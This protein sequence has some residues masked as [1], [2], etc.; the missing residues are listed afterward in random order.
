MS[1]I[2]K[3]PPRLP[4][5]FLVEESSET[6]GPSRARINNLQHQVSELVRKNQTLERKLTA[7][8]S[9]SENDLKEKAAK[10][11][12]MQV[13]LHNTQRE[14]ERSKKDLERCVLE[15]SEMK[16]ELQ[17]HSMVQQQKAL[18]AVAQEQM[19]VVELETRLLDAEK[20]R[21]L[22][23]HKITLF[24]AKE[25]ELVREIEERDIRIEDLEAMLERSN[26]SL[27][28]ERNAI[29]KAS[30]SQLTSSKDLTKAQM[31][32]EFARAEINTL[33][34]KVTSLETKVR[35]LKDREKEARSE[36]ESWLREEGSASKHQKEKKESQ[37]QL[38]AMKSELEKKKEE[39][40]EL[41]EELEEAVRSGK[42]KEKILKK[43][44][45]D[46]NEEKERLL[47]IEE[48]LHGLRAG[49]S[50]TTPGN[51][52]IRK[53]SPVKE[54]SGDEVTTK[55]KAKK[56]E[57]AVSPS[58]L[59]SK[60]RAKTK[61]SVDSSS[62]LDDSAPAPIKKSKAARKSPIKSKPKSIAVEVSDA[63]NEVDSLKTRSSKNEVVEHKPME[64]EE[65]AASANE[66]KKKKRILGTQPPPT[67]NWDP[68][69]NSGDGVI[70]AYLSPLKPDSVRATGTIP[71]AGFPSLPSS[72]LNRFG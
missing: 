24:Q 39:I 22:R 17:L 1:M 67:F 53:E 56:A 2:Q 46:A 14:L 29:R 49:I 65:Q 47:G 6:P 57:T 16:E 54:G 60:A 62:E 59:S 25:E 52:K 28:Q 51:R 13:S 11:N 64:K 66:K 36:L 10:L 31:E 71:R 3:T 70:P 32:L 37:I 4:A 42:E 55:K 38:R 45:R 19:L 30:S 5:S 35:G 48:E 8:K 23:D 43:R 72:R 68:V 61:A 63:E 50:K 69:M 33:E 12:E 40:E 15:G 7:V 34:D 58:K 27:E 18:L 20:A 41:K 9:A 44:L 26:A 21:I